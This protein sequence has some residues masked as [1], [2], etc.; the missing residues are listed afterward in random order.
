MRFI[1]A[2]AN[3][4]LVTSRAGRLTNR[5]AGGSALVLPG[6][7]WVKVSGAK[8]EAPASP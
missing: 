8:Q 5:G 4:F 6:A 3:E 7:T 1:Q 2:R